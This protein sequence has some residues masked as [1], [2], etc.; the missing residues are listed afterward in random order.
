MVNLAMS[1]SFAY[2]FGSFPCQRGSS[3][4]R[5]RCPGSPTI[6]SIL[7]LTHL[8]TAGRTQILH[9]SLC[10]AANNGIQS[11][12]VRHEASAFA[13]PTGT[14]RNPLSEHTFIQ[15]I[16]RPPLRPRARRRTYHYQSGAEKLCPPTFG[17]A[18][19]GP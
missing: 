18:L 7:Q 1:I 6:F 12:V 8:I 14:E 9:P 16:S 3:W 19:P 2:L 10:T 15:A 5:S 4:S 17:R 11:N 13:F